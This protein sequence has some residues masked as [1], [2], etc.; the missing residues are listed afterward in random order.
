[1]TI[2]ARTA[3]FAC[4]GVLS[5]ALAGCSTPA[6]ESDSSAPPP[7][8]DHPVTVSSCGVDY[9][10]AAAPERVLL[11]APGIIQTLD[12]LG[13]AESAIGYANAD[14]P[15]DG[16]DQFP[17]LTQ[18]TSDYAPSREFLI[19]AQP[20]LFLVNDEGQILGEGS[21]S[22]D[23]LASIPANL[24]V[25]GSYCAETPAG[26]TIDVVYED[27]RNLGAIYG[28]P[29]AADDLVADLEER[30]EHAASHRPDGETLTAGAV[31]IYDGTVYALSGSYYA[32]VLSA[33]G[34]ENAFADLGVS[35]AEITPEA[36]LDADLDV[37][38][39]TYLGDPTAAISDAEAL[40]ANSPAVQN[41]RVVAVD[42]TAFQSV[43]VAIVDIIEDAAHDLYDH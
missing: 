1:M 29:D 42:D 18:T 2:S 10:Y 12:A 28:V 39:V 3:T 36:V 27:I 5:I 25:L 16:L 9:T 41:G 15:V 17:G 32:A 37:I 7:A 30:V 8:S 19:S 43:G 24:Y 35:W 26:D 34:L 4:V 22:T 38:I 11:G 20:D 23:D 40:F 6:S 13:V 21:A 33:L 14:Y 31:T